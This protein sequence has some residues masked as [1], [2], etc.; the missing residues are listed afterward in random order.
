VLPA[1]LRAV[2]QM[3]RDTKDCNEARLKCVWVELRI[4]VG[5]KTSASRV[6]LIEEANPLD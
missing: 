2:R 3:T 1:A 6:G 5:A 4:A